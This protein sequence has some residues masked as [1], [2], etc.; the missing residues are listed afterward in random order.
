MD[1][2]RCSMDSRIRPARSDNGMKDTGLK[3]KQSFF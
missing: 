3:L 2:L 1:D